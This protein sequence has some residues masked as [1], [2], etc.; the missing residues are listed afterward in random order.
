MG[1][2]I[3][4]VID[5]LQVSKGFVRALPGPKLYRGACCRVSELLPGALVFSDGGF[6]GSSSFFFLFFLISASGL[7][8]GRA[9]ERT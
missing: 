4:K 5:V 6:R 9:L 2:E 3:K 8:F 7:G 1:C